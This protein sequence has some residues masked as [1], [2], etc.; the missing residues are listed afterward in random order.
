[1]ALY[2]IETIGAAGNKLTCLYLGDEQSNTELIK[3]EELPDEYRSPGVLEYQKRVIAFTATMKEFAPGYDL[4]KQSS[5]FPSTLTICPICACESL[6]LPLVIEGYIDYRNPI[7]QV[8]HVKR[9]VAIA[10]VRKAAPVLHCV[11][12]G[13][14]GPENI[15]TART[16]DTGISEKRTTDAR[17]LIVQMILSTAS[18]KEVATLPSWQKND[19]LPLQRLAEA[20]NGNSAGI[21]ET[22]A[23]HSIRKSLDEALALYPSTDFGET[24]RVGLNKVDKDLY[25]M[26]SAIRR[27]NPMLCNQL[28]CLTMATR[29]MGTNVKALAGILSPFF[30]TGKPKTKRRKDTKT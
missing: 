30:K 24:C 8:D 28:N 14:R 3:A 12:C 25:D 1:M 16:L 15:F 21:L 11:E 5:Y 19:L 2:A 4:L 6:Q 23:L 29:K 26:R 9:G 20:V 10:S 13:F 7:P 18:G 17:E 22:G 27:I